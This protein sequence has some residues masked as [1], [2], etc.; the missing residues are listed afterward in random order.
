M[1][2]FRR[3]R[4]VSVPPVYRSRLQSILGSALDNGAY[5]L[6]LQW[7]SA[8]EARRYSARIP[9]MQGELRQVKAEINQRMKEIRAAFAQRR[10]SVR[11]G[12]VAV[13]ASR[14]TGA[15]KK[16][17][18]EDKARKLE[19]LSRKQDEALAPYQ[20]TRDVIDRL[21]LQLDSLKKQVDAWLARQE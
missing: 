2:L 3:E 6:D 9:Q 19:K 16:R 7:N 18:A 5:R 14:V 15:G 21:L 12:L 20:M 10:E 8:E 11:P 17:T 4:R 1:H 13:V